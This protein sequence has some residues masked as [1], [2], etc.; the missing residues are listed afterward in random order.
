[1]IIGNKKN[2]I[3]DTNSYLSQKYIPDG[4]LWKLVVGDP[5]KASSPGVSTSAGTDVGVLQI[6]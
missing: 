2:G 6:N 3:T 4:G 5:L 1:M